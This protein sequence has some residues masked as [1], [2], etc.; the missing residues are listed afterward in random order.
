MEHPVRRSAQSSASLLLYFHMV[1]TD[2][3]G[4]Y[5]ARENV[6]AHSGS[7]LKKKS[8]NPVLKLL[9]ADFL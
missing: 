3:L 2:S 6:A 5:A 1:S 4:R 7:L 9:I 8:T